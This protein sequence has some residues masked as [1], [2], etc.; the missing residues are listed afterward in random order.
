MALRLKVLSLYSRVLRLSRSWVA[1]NPVETGVEREY[2]ESEAKLLFRK[3]AGLINELEI[4]ERIREAEARVTMAEHYKNPYPRPVN[5]PKRSYSKQE[6]KRVGKAIQKMN[7]QSRP[8][9][10]RSTDDAVGK[11]KP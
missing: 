1:T 5:L 6:G 9:Y 7:E 2:I 10:I 3:N 4:K 11:S 8:V